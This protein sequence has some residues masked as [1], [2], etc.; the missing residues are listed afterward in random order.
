MIRRKRKAPD[1]DVI[2]SDIFQTTRGEEF[3]VLHDDSLEI[4]AFET[5]KNLD[6][7]SGAELSIARRVDTSCILYTGSA[8]V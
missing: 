1:G 8:I 4:Y 7:G 2:P 6:I 3:L 5:D